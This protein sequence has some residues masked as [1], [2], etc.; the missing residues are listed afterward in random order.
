MTSNPNIRRWDVINHLIEK[1]GYETYLEVGST[2]SLENPAPN[3]WH[4]TA[5]TRV[6][7]DPKGNPGFRMKSNDFFDMLPEHV[8]FDI[9]FVDAEHTEAAV[10]CDITNSIAHLKPNGSIVVHDCNPPTARH[11]TVEETEALYKKNKD[12]SGYY[13]WTG[14][15][16]MGF[17]SS[18]IKHPEYNFRCVDVDWG[19]GVI[20]RKS[21]DDKDF[22][23][24][25]PKSF[26]EFAEKRKEYLGLITWDEF[27]SGL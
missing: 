7:V 2:G 24:T 14:T 20:Q 21:S 18:R 25:P 22:A 6:S 3:L 15:V 12:G 8:K 27:I 1:S 11:S 4:I 26:D 13:V 23:L 5:P 16:Y 19:C 17:I 10:S 9:I